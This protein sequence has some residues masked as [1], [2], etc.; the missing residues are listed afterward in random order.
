MKVL[1]SFDSLIVLFLISCTS[2]D[3]KN[4]Q[5]LW[6]LE[7]VE[8]DGID[9]TVGP[10]FIDLKPNGSFAASQLSGDLVGTYS[11]H[12]P[13]LELH[14]TDRSRFNT[15]WILK[16]FKEYF[17]ITGREEGFRNIKLQFRKIDK[18]PS[19]EEF[20]DRIVGNW[21]LYKIRRKGEVER[22]YD[23][24]FSIHKDGAYSLTNKEGNGEKGHA[25]INARHHKIIFEPD[26]TAWNAW[27]Y[28]QELRLTNEKMRIQY[29]LRKSE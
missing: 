24:W 8:V 29:S 27:F 11:F 9:R 20:E 21:E 4:I 14:S 12:S 7:E 3:K 6:Q 23:T 18:I 10:V 25:I 5:G 15:T 28:G 16:Y 22:L 26:D 19:F 2:I 1:L 13:L 17:V